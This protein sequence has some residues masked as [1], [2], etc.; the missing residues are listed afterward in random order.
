ML[1]LTNCEAHRAQYLDRS[2]EVKDLNKNKGNNI[3]RI[4]PL[5]G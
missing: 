4:E 2:L 3:F 1:I 5:Y